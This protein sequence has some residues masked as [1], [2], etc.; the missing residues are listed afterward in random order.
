MSSPEIALWRAVVLQQ[1]ID[2]CGPARRSDPRRQRYEG[3]DRY[4]SRKWLL[5]N[6]GNFQAVCEA[7]ELPPHRVR[8]E[9]ERCAALGW[10]ARKFNYTE[11]K[12]VFA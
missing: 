7:A 12:G 11:P 5:G 3:Y 4:E 9:A 8:Q 6:S 10:P 2:A 1:F